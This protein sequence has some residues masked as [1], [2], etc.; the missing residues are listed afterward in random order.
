MPLSILAVFDDLIRCSTLLPAASCESEFLQVTINQEECCKKWL[1]AVHEIEELKIRLGKQEKN[2][3]N[4]EKRLQRAQHMVDTEQQRRRK[5]EKYIRELEF[6]LQKM[7]SLLNTELGFEAYELFSFL[8]SDGSTSDV[9]RHVRSRCSSGYT[10]STESL[11]S[12]LD[13]AGFEDDLNLSLTNSR[14]KWRKH[15]PCAAVQEPDGCKNSHS[16]TA[17]YIQLDE[18]LKSRDGVPKEN[19]IVEDEELTTNDKKDAIDSRSICSSRTLVLDPPKTDLAKLNTVKSTATLNP[20]GTNALSSRQHVFCSKTALNF[21]TCSYCFER[22][23][24]GKMLIRCEDCRALCHPKCKDKVPLPCVPVGH[25]MRPRGHVMGV[26]SDYAP[27]TSPMVPS[28][29]VHCVNEVDLRG[30]NEVGIYRISGSER[31]VKELK[32][33][34]LRGNG[35]PSLSGLDIHTVCCTVKD[36][37]RS[38]KEPLVTNLLWHDF[39]IAASISD[40]EFSRAL[41]YQAISQLP[42]PNRDTLAFLIMHLQRVADCP[43]C[44]M[45]ESNIARVFGPTIVGYSTCNPEAEEILGSAKKQEAVVKCLLSLPTYYW[46]NF[47]HVEF[48]PELSPSPTCLVSPCSKFFH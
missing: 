34:F 32:E 47:L 25:N 17:E 24:F 27:P 11:L 10:R 22:V 48:E 3:S 40:P 31:E 45:P 36:F 9:P 7:R 23:K 12:E 41:M 37:L 26:L 42:Q 43:D 39:V 16:L 29:I 21:E 8:Y 28:L 13:V 20:L 44:K 14:K 5:A 4:F 19:V 2:I 6:K 38:L 18:A 1:D 30:L 35:A 33:K 46:S 15:K